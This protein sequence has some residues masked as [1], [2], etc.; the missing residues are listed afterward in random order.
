MAI[1]YETLYK[2]PLAGV[3]RYLWVLWSFFCVPQRVSMGSL[4]LIIL[5]WRQSATQRTHQVSS[6]VKGFLHHQPGTGKN[7]LGCGVLPI[8]EQEPRFRQA[9]ALI[10][11]A[12]G[13]KKLLTEEKE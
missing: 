10:L 1:Y 11:N 13:F 12:D 3:R 9:M 2:R 6:G 8:Q 5:S 7:A 4:R